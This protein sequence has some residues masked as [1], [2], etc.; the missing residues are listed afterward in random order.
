MLGFYHLLQAFSGCFTRATLAGVA[1]LLLVPTVSAQS[2]LFPPEL[3]RFQ[4]QPAHPLFTGA[5]PEHWDTKIRERGWILREGNLW[6]MWYTGYDGTRPGRKMLGYATST[7]GIN[8][9]RWA[10]NPLDAEHWIEDV[11]IVRNGDT[12]VMF[13][14][15]EG[16]RAQ[17]WTSTDGLAWNHQGRLD[18]R[19][20]S[21]K[22]ISDGPYGTPAAW[23]EDGQW[24]LFYERQD[25]GIWWATSR[26]L[27]T[28]TNQSDEP[29]L[30]PGPGTYDD[31]AV[32]MNQIVRH[33]EHYYAY[34]HGSG[35]AEPGRWC[36]CVA[37]SDDLRHWTKYPGNP[38][39]ADNHSSGIL[40]PDGNGLLLY[41]M[42][43]A[44][45]R[46]VP[47]TTPVVP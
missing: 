42:H 43:E 8:W 32:A 33:G 1:W 37:V 3:V 6:R 22:P 39:V 38:I 16:D 5:G 17:L 2:D 47:Q 46:Y 24:H 14:E 30:V 10:G 31:R 15:G 35:T 44:V 40:V 34:Y 41:T 27:A 12:L 28:W 26:D 19:R 36:T 7:D 13:A 4:P 23:L 11:M 20:T 25:Q 45:W 9:E 21:G 18:V 29:V